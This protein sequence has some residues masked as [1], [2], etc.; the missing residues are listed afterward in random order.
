LD[1]ERKL[2]PVILISYNETFL[3]RLKEI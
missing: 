3:Y 1:N 2:D